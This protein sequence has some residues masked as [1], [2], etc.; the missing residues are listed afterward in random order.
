MER[1]RIGIVIPAYNEAET[2]ADVVNSAKQYGV[3]IVVDDGSKDHTARLASLAGGDVVRHDE[4]KGYDEALN[5]GFKRSAELESE[6][7]ITL[8]GDGQHESGLIRE[9]VSKIEDGSDVVVGIRNRKQRFAER[10]FAWYTLV[11]FGIR[12]PLCGMKAYRI[13]VYN[14]M[15]RFDTY[16]SIGTQLMLFAAKKGYKLDQLAV[17]INSRKGRSRFGQFFWGNYRIIRAMLM[18]IWHVK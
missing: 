2:I 8:D 12:D 18:S 1:L 17:N 6:V 7:V 3:P 4:N 16:G 15:G 9:F 14:D 5:S 11:R 13:K 10:L